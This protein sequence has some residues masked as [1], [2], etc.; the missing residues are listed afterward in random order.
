MNFEDVA[1]RAGQIGYDLNFGG[2][3]AFYSWPSQGKSS[4]YIADLITLEA[5]ELY[6][7]EFLLNLARA[8]QVTKIHIIAHSVGNQALLRVLNQI[9]T[10]KI[11]ISFG[12]IFLTGADI[13]SYLFQNL[14]PEF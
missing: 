14:A 4:A 5:S 1:M 6:I 12:Q 9:L 3:M 7:K 2:I 11:S 8:N 13:D 10:C